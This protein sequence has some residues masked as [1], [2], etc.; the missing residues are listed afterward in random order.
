MAWCTAGTA[1][2]SEIQITFGDAAAAQDEWAAD[3][4]RSWRHYVPVKLTNATDKTCWYSVDVELSVDGGP[5]AATERVSAPLAP[6]Q[7]FIAQ[8][9]DLDEHVKFSADAKDATTTQKFETK[10]AQIKRGPAFDYY[11]MTFKVGERTG[12]GAATL[13]S[14][15]LD[16]KAIT[17]GMPERLWSADIDYVYLL[18]LDANGDIITKA[19]NSV[20]EPKVPG[21]TTV[22]FA[23]GGGES[24]GYNRNLMPLSTYDTVVD[25]AIQIQPAYTDLDR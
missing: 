1:E 13:M 24:N 8:A 15:D 20:D 25:W 23:I 4:G 17:E 9:F 2:A 6:G 5:K 14:A 10:V 19:G 3:L 21:K 18:G 22:Q 7:S 12:S 16:I 11:D